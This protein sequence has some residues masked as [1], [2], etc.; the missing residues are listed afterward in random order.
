MLA[1]LLVLCSAFLG[2]AAWSAPPE[3]EPTAVDIVWAVRIP[4][5][6]GVKL[7]AV[8]YKPLN[9]KEHVPAVFVKTP[10]LADRLSYHDWATYFAQGGYAALVVDARGRGDSEGTFRALDGDGRDGYDVVEWLAKQPWC[11]G[12]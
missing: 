7:H 4:M 2:L 5:R 8:M 11:N 1:R 12:K 6:D 3:T 9:S 10:Y